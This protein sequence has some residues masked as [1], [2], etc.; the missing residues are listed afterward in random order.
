ME[1]SSIGMVRSWVPVVRGR[2]ESGCN[3]ITVRRFTHAYLCVSV[4][5]LESCAN[6][7]A[8]RWPTAHAIR[9]VLGFDLDEYS[10]MSDSEPSY[11]DRDAGKV[12]VYTTTMGIVRETYH[13][14]LKVKQI[15]RT[16]MVK[17]EERDVF[18]SSEAQADIRERMKCSVILVPQVFVEGQHIGV[19]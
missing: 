18:M 5:F 7:C 10:C 16:L 8:Q 15:L 3:W 2:L 17:F 14:C 11:K 4:T 1:S 6:M 12:V 13:K 19:R 9:G